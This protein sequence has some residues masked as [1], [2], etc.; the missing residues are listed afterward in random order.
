MPWQSGVTLQRT[1]AH[2]STYGLAGR[3]SGSR[4]FLVPASKLEVLIDLHDKACSSPRR[5]QAKNVSN[6]TS[7]ASP[8]SLT[9]ETWVGVLIR[10]ELGSAGVIDAIG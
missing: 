2:C 8:L 9:W 1:A 5:M 10:R 3:R 4:R 6:F 7:F